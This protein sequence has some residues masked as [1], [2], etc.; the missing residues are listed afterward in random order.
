MKNNKT[1]SLKINAALSATKTLLSAIIPLIVFPYVT[2]IIGAVNYGKINFV[3]SIVTYFTMIAGLG[4][5]TYAVREGA[6]YRNNRVQC[7]KFS[8]QIFTINIISTLVSL[9]LFILTV[10]CWKKLQDYGILVLVQSLG[11]I[12]TT[13]SVEWIYT[14]YEDYIYIT[15]RYVIIQ[16]ISIILVFVLVRE[17]NDYVLYSTITVG[18]NFIANLFNLIHSRKYVDIKL[19]KKTDAARHLKSILIMFCNEISVQIYVNSD[20]T[21]LGILNSDYSVGIYSVATKIYAIIKRI[22]NTVLTVTIPRLA[23]YYGCER[24]KAYDELQKK[25]AR[26][27]LVITIPIIV[28]L[29]SLSNEIV[30]I[31]SGPAY[32]DAAIPLKILSVSLAFSVCATFAGNLLLIEKKESKVL[33]STSVAA[34]INIALNLIMIPKFGASAAALTTAIS[35]FFVMAVNIVN[36]RLGKRFNNIDR[37]FIVEI[38][39]ITIL[40]YIACISAR[41]LFA[42]AI[43]VVLLAVII[44]GIMTLAVFVFFKEPLLNETLQSLKKKLA[45]G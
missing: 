7:S 37:N 19:L 44:T 39:L 31:I 18:S 42:N 30:E 20:I 10:L 11:I 16:A 12:S 36:S 15:K 32:T 3:A 17:Q 8:S 1:I 13:I 35:E 14:I 45:K 26:A 22:V 29:F 6:A 38:F 27:L 5:T 25:I 4:I 43:V 24:I 28:G 33:M 40:T 21:M 2:R 9:M 41:K 23:N 34:A